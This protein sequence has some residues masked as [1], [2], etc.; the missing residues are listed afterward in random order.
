MQ[1]IEAAVGEHNLF[2]ACSPGCCQRSN[3]L[4]AQRA[5]ATALLA[6]LRQ[7]ILQQLVTVHR[8]SAN[9]GHNNACSTVCHINSISQRKLACNTCQKRSRHRITSTGNIKHLNGGSR[10]VQHLLSINQAHAALT[11]GN[12]N[13]LNMKFFACSL[14]HTDNGFVRVFTLTACSLTHF[15]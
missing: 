5:I 14:R 15:L 11:A 13:I 3:L 6:F 9:L 8:I 1:N 4:P 2:A 7:Q 12:N 10:T